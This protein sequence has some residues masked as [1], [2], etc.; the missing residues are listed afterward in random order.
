MIIQL[1]DEFIYTEQSFPISGKENGSQI[2][3]VHIRLHILSG[4]HL[5][6]HRYVITY[7]AGKI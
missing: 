7:R 3:F 2:I 6:D 4:N 5:L 1:A